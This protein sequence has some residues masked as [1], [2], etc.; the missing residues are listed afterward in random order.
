MHEM[1]RKQINIPKVLDVSWMKEK[2]P[3][4]LR[5]LLKFQ[6]LKPFLEMTRNVYPDLIKIFYTNLSLEGK[7]LVSSMKGIK[8]LITSKV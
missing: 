6:R 1:S 3:E 7:N 8:M 5:A 2:N 4:E